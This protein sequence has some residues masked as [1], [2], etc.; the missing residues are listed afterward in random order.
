MRKTEETKMG[1][2]EKRACTM[3]RLAINLTATV[4]ALY[5]GGWVMLANS[6]FGTVAA[7]HAGTLTL[8]KL[9]I[10]AIK[11]ALSAT[12]AG[13]IWCVGYVIGNYFREDND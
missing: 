6:I 3:I 11:C 5:I 8:T 9:M 13:A 4:I 7:F 12:V 1:P 2:W 10:A